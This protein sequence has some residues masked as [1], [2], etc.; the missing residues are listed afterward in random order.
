MSQYSKIE[1]TNRTWNPTTGCN[2]ISEG[3]RNC[4]AERLA[5][6]LQRMGNPRYPNG[7]ALTLHHDRIDEPKHWK[8]PQR[9]FVNSMSDL[10]HPR[11]PFSFIESAFQTMEACPQHTFQ[12]LTKRS[13]RLSEEARHLPWPR[14][15][16]MGV[17]VE[18]SAALYRVDHLRSVPAQVRFLSCEPLLAGL[19]GLKLGGIH[20]VIV[21]GESG[22]GARPM[23]P[24]WVREIRDLCR[25]E[26]VRFFFKQWGGPRKF[27][28][29][30]LLDG[31][32]HDEYPE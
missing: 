11:I 13:K 20:W 26:N 24:E 19:D 14:N 32:T 27:M 7:F 3:C 17:S 9:I 12:I 5:G 22:P 30:R 8:K 25:R 6:R 10:F 28:T 15:V 16:W 2:R 31:T 21:G 1:W 18:N 29:G 23:H 4:Y